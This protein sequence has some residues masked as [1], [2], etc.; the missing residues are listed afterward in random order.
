MALTTGCKG[1][2]NEV[3]FLEHVSVRTTINYTIRG[4]LEI[5]LT[6]PAGNV[7][8]VTVSKNLYIYFLGSTVQLLTPRKYDKSPDGFF[9]WTF[10]SVM[11][12][13]ELAQGIWTLTVSDNV[14]HKLKK[15]Y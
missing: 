1:T 2:N 11:T 6:S 7:V 10:M 8:C 9:N 14:R 4:A 3:I 12:W 5:H 15:L 13:G